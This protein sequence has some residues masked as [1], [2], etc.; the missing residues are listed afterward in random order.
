MMDQLYVAI[1]FWCSVAALS[2]LAAVVLSDR[3]FADYRAGQEDD[4]E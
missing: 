2:V 4:E 1:A 3:F